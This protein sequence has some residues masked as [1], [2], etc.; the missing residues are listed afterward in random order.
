[1]PLFKRDLIIAA[2]DPKTKK[3]TLYQIPES[4]WRSASKV[5]KGP[6]AEHINDVVSAGGVL[7]AVPESSSG[8]IGAAC[9]LI[10]L[11]SI[12]VGSIEAAPAPA[13]KT[14]RRRVAK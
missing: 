4:K 11:A 9:Y 10:N 1:M 14:V 12:N 2:V 8:G 5:V 3:P 7:A 13:A 6:L